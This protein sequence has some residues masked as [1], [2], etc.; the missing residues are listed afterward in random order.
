MT[1]ESSFDIKGELDNKILELHEK[2]YSWFNLMW[3]W[4]YKDETRTRTKTV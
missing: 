1:S 2:E 3:G 4:S